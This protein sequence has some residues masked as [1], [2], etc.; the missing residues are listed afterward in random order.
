[1]ALVTKSINWNAAVW[2]AAVDAV[3]ELNG[4][5]DT[6]VDPQ[7]PLITIPNPVSKIQFFNAWVKKK[8]INEITELSNRQALANIVVM[9]DEE[10]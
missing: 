2:N 3:A 6:I 9:S 4:W 5:T 10:V 8:A 1:M 7:D